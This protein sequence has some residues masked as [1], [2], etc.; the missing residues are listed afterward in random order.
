MLTVNTGDLAYDG[1]VPPDA[2]HVADA[3]RNRSRKA[4]KI[5]LRLM[6]GSGKYE[7]PQARNLKQVA[8][9]PQLGIALNRLQ[10]NGSSSAM[11][12]L[13]YLEHGQH[14]P[15][16]QA[17]DS[18]LHLSDMGIHGIM[19]LKRAKRI[20]IVRDPFSRTLS[21]F[22]DKFRSPFFQ[23]DF[24][25]FELSPEGFSVFLKYL[26][27]G[28][29]RTNS[30]WSP[31]TDRLLLSP[32]RYHA[33]IAFSA[34]PSQFLQVLCQWIPAVQ[35]RWKSFSGT[36]IGGPPRTDAGA[37]VAAFY[38]SEDIGRVERIYHKDLEVPQIRQEAD[39]M[40]ERFLNQSS[41]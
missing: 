8:F 16:M 34:F 30:H 17:K 19:T 3:H 22:L 2:S 37:K 28:G 6:F 24:G 12:F 39:D 32:D 4:E 1:W 7:A 31:Q 38:N 9:F 29:L 25:P 18:S 15:A 36:E 35:N 26:E 21:A 11:S 14:T 13:Y 10:K 40:R 33:V 5:L 23:R 20:V 41:P 27:N